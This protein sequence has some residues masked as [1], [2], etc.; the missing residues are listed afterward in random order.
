[1]PIEA[2]TKDLFIPTACVCCGAEAINPTYPID[3]DHPSNLSGVDV[4]RAG[5]GVAI[6]PDCGHEFIQPVPQA[7]FLAAYY[8]S[9]MSKAKSGFYRERAEGDI[10]ARFRQRYE[11]WLTILERS[12]GRKARLLDVGAGLGMFLRLAREKGFEVVGVEPNGEAA[13]CLR[14]NFDIPVVNGL[15]EDVSLDEQVDIITMWD[16][17][18]HLANPRAA[19]RKAAGLIHDKGLLVLEIPA[20]DSLLH[21][22]AKFLYRASNG[23]I[24]R[25]LYLVCGV[26]HLH[27][28]SE[29]DITRLLD[30]TGFKIQEVH[31]GETELASLYHG[32]SGERSV[33]TVVYNMALV[34]VF[35][36]ARLLRKQNKLIVFARKA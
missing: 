32:G 18:E 14:K 6:C 29:A 3:T 25:P 5:L 10:P 28:F 30:E 13:E 17:L 11:R 12:L 8:A 4:R 34:A 26:H 21:Y 24:R 22:L 31:R 23:K 2:Q 36:M 20:R 35:G 19:L 7:P 33:S 27:Y 1:M 16:L 15:F 9:Y